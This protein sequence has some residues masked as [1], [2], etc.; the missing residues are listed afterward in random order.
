MSRYKLIY[1]EEA[2]VDIKE[3]NTWYNLQQ[4]GLGKKFK[5]DILLVVKAIEKN[6]FFASVK[7]ANVRTASCNIFPYA[8]HYLV[9]EQNKLVRV[10]SVFH[11]SRKSKS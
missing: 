6:P 4:K 10:I 2:K 5:A 3:A 1:S 9:D 7:F 8:V 11:F